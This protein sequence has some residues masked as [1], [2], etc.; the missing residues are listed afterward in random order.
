[1]TR[2]SVTIILAVT[3]GLA[4]LRSIGPSLPIGPAGADVGRWLAWLTAVGAPTAVIALLRAI[5]LAVG[6]YLVVVIVL[7]LMAHATG[8]T[9]LATLV[10]GVTL[11]GLRRLLTGA[12]GAGLAV[13][14]GLGTLSPLAASAETPRP[15]P[16]MRELD[17][18]QPPVETPTTTTTTTPA[19]MPGPVKDPA[20]DP[21]IATWTIAPG[22]HLWRVAQRTL[23]RSW[24]RRPSD[25]QTLRYLTA[26]IEQNRAVL[27]VPDDP[28][29]V[30]A[31]QVFALPP[32]PPIPPG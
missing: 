14:L 27:V 4:A 30:F 24:G 3:L 26:L 5:T 31:G 15:P 12:A 6:T 17:P 21:P 7:D 11:P 28:D 32:I 2:R 29:L 9:W 22:D 25:A 8:L 23:N 10:R 18:D 1:M 16:T 20:Q 19:P 13:S